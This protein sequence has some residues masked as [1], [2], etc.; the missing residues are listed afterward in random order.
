MTPVVI[1]RSTCSGYESQEVSQGMTGHP[2][3][4]CVVGEGANKPNNLH[5]MHA[6]E[7]AH[8]RTDWQDQLNCS[9]THRALHCNVA[10]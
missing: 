5:A 8:V 9:E 10:N 1:H 6:V 2:V 3:Q 4:L 7:L